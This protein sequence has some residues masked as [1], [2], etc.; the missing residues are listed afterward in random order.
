VANRALHKVFRNKTEKPYVLC[1]SYSQWLLLMGWTIY[2]SHWLTWVTV[3]Q[4]HEPLIRC[5]TYFHTALHSVTLFGRSKDVS[6]WW[7]DKM[8]AVKMV[9]TKWYDAPPDPLVVRGFLPSAIA[10]SR[11]WPLQLPRFSLNI[12]HVQ[13]IDFLKICLLLDTEEQSQRSRFSC[14][15]QTRCATIAKRTEERKIRL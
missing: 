15:D 9:R 6:G 4:M 10:A 7:P 8:V 11:L 12:W 5:A 3:T 2:T 14:I 13:S 1:F